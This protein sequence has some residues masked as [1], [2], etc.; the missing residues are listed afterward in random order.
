MD[1]CSWGGGTGSDWVCNRRMTACG[2]MSRFCGPDTY[3][4]HSQLK[5]LARGG[6]STSALPAGTTS[7]RV[8]YYS[9]TDGSCSGGIAAGMEPNGYTMPTGLNQCLPYAGFAPLLPSS[10]GTDGEYYGVLCHN[11]SHLKISAKCTDPACTAC[12]SFDY[13]PMNDVS[14]CVDQTR[15]GS[16]DYKI[17]DSNID[18]RQCFSGSGTSGRY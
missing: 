3:F 1:K 13:L 9:S 15:L 10:W 2:D 6:S 5:C 16:Y 8:M 7:G 11:S 18:V 4:D 17:L 14:A 12:S